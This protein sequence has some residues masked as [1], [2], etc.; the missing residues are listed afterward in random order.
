MGTPDLFAAGS[1]LGVELDDELLVDR[2]VDVLA[3]RQSNDLAGEIVRLSIDPIDAVL[4]GGKVLGGGEQHE[5]LGTLADRDLIADLA[6][7]ARD[8]DFAAVHLHVAVANELAGL[9]AG[10]SEAEAIADVVE[11]GLELLEQD[12]AGDAGLI[13]GL[14][15]V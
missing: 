11:A 2:Q 12:L 4:T 10:D 9:A 5:L 6:L 7:E 8:V 3:L 1:L 14:L 15:V 13:R